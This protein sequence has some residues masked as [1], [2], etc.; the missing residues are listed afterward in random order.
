MWKVCGDTPWERTRLGRR[1]EGWDAVRQPGGEGGRLE[2]VEGR[3]GVEEGGRG[4][5]GWEQI[6]HV[7]FPGVL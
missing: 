5:R 6:P 2:E 1:G 7:D 3:K 4:V